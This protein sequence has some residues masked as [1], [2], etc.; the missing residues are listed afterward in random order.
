MLIAVWIVS[1]LVALLFLAAGTMK[2]TLPSSR[3]T[4]QFPWSETVG[5]PGTRVIG[6]LEMVGAI[7]VIVPALTGIAPLLTPIAATGLALIQLLAFVFHARRGETSV[8]PMNAVLF[9]LAA[10]VAV[11]RFL[12]V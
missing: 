7:G 9:V 6:V 5:L 11:A 1:G 8:M 3:L 10:F 4:T 12:G 2:A